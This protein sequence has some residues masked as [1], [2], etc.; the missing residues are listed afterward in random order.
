MIGLPPV[1]KVQ[2][3]MSN[4]HDIFSVHFLSYVVVGVLLGTGHNRLTS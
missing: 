1:Q 3:L 4:V 2:A